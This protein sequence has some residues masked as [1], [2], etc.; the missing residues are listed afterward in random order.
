MSRTIELEIP[1]AL[2]DRLEE[3]AA[4]EGKT[5]QS[6]FVRLLESYLSSKPRARPA[7]EDDPLLKLAGVIDSNVTDVGS[8]HDDYIGQALLD[9]HD[10]E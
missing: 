1:D 4:R 5:P 10:A 3:A 9:S 2:H 7:P 8:R 6:V